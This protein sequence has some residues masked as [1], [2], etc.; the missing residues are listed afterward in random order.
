MAPGLASLKA[1][2]QSRGRWASLDAGDRGAVQ[3]GE[4]G[5]EDGDPA[6]RRAGQPCRLRHR[7]S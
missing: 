6:A 7:E 5:V 2:M 1:P 4:R 3:A